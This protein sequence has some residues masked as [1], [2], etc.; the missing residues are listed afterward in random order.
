MTFKEFYIADS[1]G[2]SNCVVRSLCKILNKDYA[3]VFNELC[4][5]AKKLNCASYNDIKAF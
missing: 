3:I 5:T 1:D 4:K 2:K